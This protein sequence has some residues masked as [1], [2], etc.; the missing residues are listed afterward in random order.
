MHLNGTERAN[1]KILK[2]NTEHESAKLRKLSKQTLL[3][4]Y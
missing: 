4:I 1:G 3:I 2:G